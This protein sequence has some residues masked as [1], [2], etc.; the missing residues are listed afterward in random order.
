LLTV[1]SGLLIAA[2][3]C[4]H[5]SSDEVEPKAPP[6][7]V[8]VT[9]HYALSV[10]VFVL[11]NGSRQRLGLVNPG[12][13]SRFQVSSAF[14]ASGGVAFQAGPGVGAQPYTSTEIFI[15]PGDVVDLEIAAVLFNST[16]TIR[17]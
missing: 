2:A 3:A 14:L 16:A 13:V 15:H 11:A 12:L 1:M 10:E 5:K 8:E 9:N 6:A 4:S 17:P 7:V